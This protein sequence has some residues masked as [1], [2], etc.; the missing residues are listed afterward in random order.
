MSKLRGWIQRTYGWRELDVEDRGITVKIRY[1]PSHNTV[2][3]QPKAEELEDPMTAAHIIE[4]LGVQV[5]VDDDWVPITAEDAA[6]VL[7]ISLVASI[8]QRITEA[9][10]VPSR[11]A[12]S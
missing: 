10:Q 9:E 6:E 7:P 11:S 12:D 2:A 1:L 3:S 8:I 5:L 4:R